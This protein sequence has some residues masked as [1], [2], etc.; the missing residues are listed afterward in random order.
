MKEVRQGQPGGPRP[1]VHGA[2]RSDHTPPELVAQLNAISARW[3]ARA[4]ERGFSIMA[5]GQEPSTASTPDFVLAVARDDGGAPVGFLRLV[6]CVGD[7][8]GFSLDLMR[9]VPD[10]PNGLTEFLIA[11]AAL[12][13]GAARWGLAPV[14]E[15]RGLGPAVRQRGRC[16]ALGSRDR[17]SG[18]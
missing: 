14:A 12:A 4:P 7:H 2:P 18:S 17:L 10:A 1:R 6:P 11:N 3:R 5:L 9:R 8:P 15:L 13:L 16:R